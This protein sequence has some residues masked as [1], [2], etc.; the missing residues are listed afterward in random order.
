MPWLLIGL[1]SLVGLGLWAWSKGPDVAVLSPGTL[2]GIS[3]RVGSS[4]VFAAPQ[5]GQVLG[6]AVLGTGIIGGFSPAG[7]GTYGIAAN[8]GGTAVVSITWNDA[9]GAPQVS[10]VSVTAS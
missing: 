5:G 10:T 3:L 1:V 6:G 4:V 7:A 8:Q 9:Q 2:S